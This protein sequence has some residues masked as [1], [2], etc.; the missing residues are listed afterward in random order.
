MT[1]SRAVREMLEKEGLLPRLKRGRKAKY[2]TEDERLEA[3]R[4]H[5][6]EARLRYDARLKAAML[7]LARMKGPVQLTSREL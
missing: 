4:R 7:E 6:K 3:L 2:A 5:R 1:V